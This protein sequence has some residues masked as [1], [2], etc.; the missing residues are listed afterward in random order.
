MSEAIGAV[1][2]DI[3]ANM[4]TLVRSLKE[5]DKELKVMQTQMKRLSDQ[6]AKS[7]DQMT[8]GAQAFE[9]VGKDLTKSVTLPLVAFAAAAIKAA[10]PAG[11]FTE[12]LKDMGIEALVTLQP[13]G[14]ALISAF[15]AFEPTIRRAISV[16][17]LLADKFGALNPETQRMVI[18]SGAAAAA[19]GPLIIAGAATAKVVGIAVAGVK[20][21]VS[22]AKIFSFVVS[23]PML[24]AIAAIGAALIGLELG[25]YF[26]DE[27]KIVQL[28]AAAAISFAEEQFIYLDA[29]WKGVVAA[30]R[31]AW[32]STMGFVQER[33]AA[34]IED[35][36]EALAYVGLIS[37]E[38]ERSAKDSAAK[39][40]AAFGNFSY[41]DEVA[42]INKEMAAGLE[43]VRQTYQR[44]VEQIEKE[45]NGQDRKGQD[46][47]QHL[48][49]SF[50]K[51]GDQIEPL[52]QPLRDKFGAFLAE[53]DKYAAGSQDRAAAWKSD[54]DSVK[55]M[56][57]A[58]ADAK[59]AMEQ[60]QSEAE[61]LRFEIY[62]EEKLQADIDRVYELAA[63]FPEILGAPEVQKAISMLTAD[64]EKAINKIKKKTD[65]WQ[66][67][68]RNMF[69]D[70]G[71]DASRTFADFATGADV[72]FDQVLLSWTRMAIEMAAQQWVFGPA[73][74]AVGEKLF[75]PAPAAATAPVALKASSPVAMAATSPLDH[76]RRSFGSDGLTAGG[77][78]SVQIYDQRSGGQAVQTSESR[79]PDGEK[80]LRVLIRDE[81][82]QMAGDGGMDRVLGP[83]YG[84]RRRP[85]TR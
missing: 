28:A 52:L 48:G 12:R 63:A 77:G 30:I 34:V 16:V 83:T 76:M 33:L 38:Q 31:E 44:T 78:V 3:T 60:M 35:G 80:M 20:N 62:P 53:V 46:P 9:R 43:E 59:K 13:I 69:K 64:Y 27:F 45:F 4:A 84:T 68:F 67:K 6:A 82:G 65:T 72:A 85:R 55:E 21:L 51:I 79:G 37:E 11:K 7:F 58:T 5:A 56:T 18:I 22:V 50:S 81:V 15:D 39:M 26:Y 47:L 40:R 75:G 70:F 14:N 74:G 66:D 49:S 24:V 25:T 29:A 36:S 19:L 42:R 32:D 17:G 8:K 23:P 54:A 10:D 1:R 71:R 73:F 41:K 57:K 61:R 2:I